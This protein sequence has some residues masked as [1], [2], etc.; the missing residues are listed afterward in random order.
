MLEIYLMHTVFRRVKDRVKVQIP[1]AT[2]Q[3]YWIDNVSR[4]DREDEEME[5]GNDPKQDTKTTESK[6][7]EKKTCCCG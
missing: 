4:T 5:M 7:L 2:A 6:T 1:H 3:N